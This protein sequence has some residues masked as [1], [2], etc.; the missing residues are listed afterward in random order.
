LAFAG[1]IAVAIWLTATPAAAAPDFLQQLMTL[2][3]HEDL[4]DTNFV[5][6]MIQGSFDSTPGIRRTQAGADYPVSQM[7]SRAGFGLSSIFIDYTIPLNKPS[8]AEATGMRAALSISSFWKDYCLSEQDVTAAFQRK[9]DVVGFA[10]DGPGRELIWNKPMLNS[11]MQFRVIFTSK[12]A[13]FAGIMQQ[14]S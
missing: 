12:C 14:F 8:N 3:N 10:T 13:V 7:I 6:G 4:L 1:Q 5:K 11:T 9:P 2:F